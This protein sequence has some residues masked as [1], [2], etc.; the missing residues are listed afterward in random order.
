MVLYWDVLGNSANTTTGLVDFNAG[1]SAAAGP[2]TPKF[3]WSL[4]MLRVIVGSQAATSLQE[5]FRVEL[6]CTLWDPNLLRFIVS[7]HGLHTAP[8]VPGQTIAWDFP[9]DQTVAT[10]TNITM[11]GVQIET[12]AVTPRINLIGLFST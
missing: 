9:L 7:G 4:K 8:A 3:N 12:T 10:N 6:L 11:Q 5:S 1:I 2:Y